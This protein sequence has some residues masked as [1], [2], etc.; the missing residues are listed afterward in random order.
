M[1]TPRKEDIQQATERVKIRLPIEKIRS[2]PKFRN[3]SE[4]KYHKLIKSAETFAL[5][6]LEIILKEKDD[7]F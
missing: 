6:I 7:V 4:E 1:E 3:I 5:L 2:I